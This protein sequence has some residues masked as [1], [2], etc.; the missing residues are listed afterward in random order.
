[1]QPGEMK[2][3]NEAGSYY[4]VRGNYAASPEG[5]KQTQ[6][7]LQEAGGAQAFGVESQA[8]FDAWTKANPALAYDLA[9]RR[10]PR[11]PQQQMPSQVGVALG[12]SFG[13]N[14]MNNPVGAATAAADAAVRPTQGAVDMADALRPQTYPVL[15]NVDYREVEQL[16][17]GPDGVNRRLAAPGTQP[18]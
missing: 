1:M 13:T 5:R 7:K 2:D 4:G 9:Q 16:F 3:Y 18:R 15:K 6:Q 12:T 11:L 8:A 14:N 17:Y 10:M